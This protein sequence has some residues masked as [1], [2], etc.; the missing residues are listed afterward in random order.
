MDFSPDREDIID[1]YVLFC[2]QN[3]ADIL[4]SFCFDQNNL[5]KSLDNDVFIVTRLILMES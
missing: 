4:L 5:F 3:N 2:L 1:M